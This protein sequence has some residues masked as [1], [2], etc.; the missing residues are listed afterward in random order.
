MVVGT[1]DY[2]KNYRKLPKTLLSRLIF[3]DFFLFWFSEWKLSKLNEKN[4]WDSVVYIW[5]QLFVEKS[6]RICHEMLQLNFSK[7]LYIS[8]LFDVVKLSQ[9]TKI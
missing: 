8:N 9:Y 1:N 2:T 3:K 5:C 6:L 7:N 4:F